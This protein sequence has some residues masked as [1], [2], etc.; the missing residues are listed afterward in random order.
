MESSSA[1]KFGQ[2]DNPEIIDLPIIDITELDYKTG[3][4]VLDAFVTYGFLY[5]STGSTPFTSSLLQRTFNVSASLFALPSDTKRNFW[6]ESATNRGYTGERNEILDPAHQSAGDLKEAWNFGEFNVNGRLQQGLPAEVAER[7]AERELKEFEDACRA[8]CER[9]LELLA[10]ALEVED[11]SWFSKRHGRPSGSIVRLLRYPAQ[12]QSD[13]KADVGAGAH[14]D[15]GSLTLLFQRQGQRGLEVRDNEGAWKGVEVVPKG[16]SGDVPPIVV[17][18][19]DLLSYW[20]NGLLKSTVHR[21]I[22]PKSAEEDRYSIVYFCHPK[23]DEGLVAVPSHV[24]RDRGD[25][26]EDETVGYGGG[27][28]GKALTAKEHLMR[29]LEATY[30]TRK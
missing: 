21:V 22:L 9:V 3:K 7:G 26:N 1:A 4:K 6:I 27:S 5:L 14:S 2:C 18:I 20:T 23:D 17:N 25:M 15:Y 28:Q 10:L 19:G 13:E 11:K 8:T 12:K 16:C 24:V 29:R 30:G